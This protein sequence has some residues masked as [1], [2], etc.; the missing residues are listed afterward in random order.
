MSNRL[1]TWDEL[2]TFIRADL[3]LKRYAHQR[4]NLA[5]HVYARCVEG[6]L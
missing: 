4:Y 1:M 5:K 3:K 6:E 2:W